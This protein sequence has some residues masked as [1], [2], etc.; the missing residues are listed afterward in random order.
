MSFTAISY[1]LSFW[2]CTELDKVAEVRARLSSTETTTATVKE[3]WQRYE[4]TIE[5]SED[6]PQKLFRIW[7]TTKGARVWIDDIVLSRLQ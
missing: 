3:D 5:L 6:K 7:T 2:A 1:R 4:Y